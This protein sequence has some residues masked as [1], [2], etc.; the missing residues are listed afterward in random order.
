[1]IRGETGRPSRGLFAG[2]IAGVVSIGCCVGPAVAALTGIASAAVAID[3]ANFL[4]S[5]WGWAFK[6]AGVASGLAAIGLA[7]RSRR[8]CRARPLG[9]FRYALIVTITGMATY[10]LLYGVTTWLGGLGDASAV[11]AKG[12]ASALPPVRVL[13]PDLESR[14]SSALEQV[15]SRYPTVELSIAGLSR[16]GVLVKTLWVPPQGSTGERYH[17]E[18]TE[19]IEDSREATVLLLQTIARTNPE[20]DHLGAFE[21]RVIVPIWSRGQVLE[22]GDPRDFR[23]FTR[24]SRFQFDAERQSGYA[25]LYGGARER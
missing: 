23:D 15:A 25:A 11:T 3:A 17:A 1:M 10:G 21:D 16:D 20:I 6:V 22:A 24:F 8:R 4:Y 19:T 13:G 12:R 9:L 2:A 14:V 18:L 7:F 5:E